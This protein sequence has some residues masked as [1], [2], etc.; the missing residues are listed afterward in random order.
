VDSLKRDCTFLA[1]EIGKKTLDVASDF[2]S[3]DDLLHWVKSGK[4]G[5]QSNIQTHRTVTQ[6]ERLCIY[7]AI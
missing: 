2:E 4:S 3:I 6:E 5:Y 1:K 7:S